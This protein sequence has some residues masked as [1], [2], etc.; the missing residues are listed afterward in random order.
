MD[1]DLPARNLPAWTKDAL[2]ALEDRYNSFIPD[3]YSVLRAVFV[4]PAVDN[5]STCDKLLDVAG[6]LE[7]DLHDIAIISSDGFKKSS[8]VIGKAYEKEEL[9]ASKET[10][11]K[12]IKPYSDGNIPDFLRR[13]ISKLILENLSDLRFGELDFQ[14][15]LHRK[16]ELILWGRTTDSEYITPHPDAVL[17][18]RGR[19]EAVKAAVERYLELDFS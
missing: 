2:E 18:Q 17:S 3:Y 10:A 6:G 13:I 1:V 19:L 4:Y 15:Q 14:L 8:P 5:K 16:M 7:D 12:R 9:L 11:R